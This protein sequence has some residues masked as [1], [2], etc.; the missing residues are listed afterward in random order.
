MDEIVAIFDKFG[1][2]VALSIVL[3]IAVYK[4]VKMYINYLQ[5]SVKDLLNVINSCTDAINKN[6]EL[7]KLI[8]NYL[9]KT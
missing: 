5:S 9:T 4:I 8:Y 1:F 6:T 2:S 3:L 7:F